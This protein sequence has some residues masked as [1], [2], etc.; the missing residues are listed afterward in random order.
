[1]KKESSRLW[2]KIQ[3]QST[4]VNNQSFI[5]FEIYYLVTD[6]GF[7]HTQLEY[8]CVQWVSFLF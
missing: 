7:S 8:L 4:A 6:F 3:N 5:Y 2:E 1:M